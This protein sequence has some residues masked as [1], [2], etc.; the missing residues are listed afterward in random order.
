LTKASADDP[1]QLRLLSAMLQHEVRTPLSA[2]VGFA[3]L[4]DPGMS[5]S[6]LMETVQRI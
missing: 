2:L 1:S 3:E 6:E 4:L 5:P